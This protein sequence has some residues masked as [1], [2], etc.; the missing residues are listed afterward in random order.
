MLLTIF[1]KI[2]RREANPESVKKINSVL[3]KVN[4]RTVSYMGGL[5]FL[6]LLAFGISVDGF[7]VA[8]DFWQVNFANKVFEGRTD[9]IWKNFTS[10]YL[11]IPSLDFYR[12]LLGF[13]FLFD[14]AVYKTWSP[15]YHATN[16]LFYIS[17]VIMLFIL[18]RR[19]TRSWPENNSQSVSYLGAALFAVSPLHCEDVCW[20]SGRAD[21]LC[22]PIYLFSMWCVV[23][24]HQD[25][26]RR[27]YIMALVS[28]VLALMSK[29]IGVGLPLVI[30]AY[31]FLWPVEESYAEL[32]DMPKYGSTRFQKERINRHKAHLEMVLKD[33]RKRKKKKDEKKKEEEEALRLE[34]EG[35][36]E[37]DGEDEDVIT[38]GDRFKFA[39]LRSWPFFVLAVLY[40]CVRY[41]ALGTFI[42]GYTGMIGGSLS[43]HLILRWF[44]LSYLYRILIPV[45]DI[46]ASQ[47]STPVWT[48]GICLICASVVVAIRLFAR[49]DPRK[50]L[51]F[52]FVW[53]VSTTL[54]LVKLWGLG[55]E[56]ETSRLL[57]FFTMAY[58]ALWPVL[59]FHPGR[60]QDAFK[61]PKIA[62]R[63]LGILSAIILS[64]VVVAYAWIAFS[65]SIFWVLGG[66]ELRSVWRQTVS[67][68]ESL[69]PGERI[70][71]LGVP[72]DLHGAHVSFNGST[73][74]TLL[75]P[76]FVKENLSD[77]VITFEPY[78]V[79]PAEV[80]NATRFKIYLGSKK[81]KGTYVWK[82]ESGKLEAVEFK[83]NFI[84]TPSLQLPLEKDGETASWKLVGK[85][86]GTYKEVDGK[87][88]L[89][90]EDIKD[91]DALKLTGLDLSPFS[92]DFLE[93]DLRV[94]Q[95]KGDL[96]ALLPTAVSWNHQS[97]DQ[98]R[99]DWVVIALKPDKL[100]KFQTVRL[101]LSHYWRWFTSSAINSFV[102]RLPEGVSV[103]FKD[104][105]LVKG[106]DKIPLTYLANHRLLNNGE[107]LVERRDRPIEV[108]FDATMIPGASSIEAQ[109]TKPNYF[110]DSYMMSRR[111]SAVG[112]SINFDSARGLLVLKPELFPEAAYYQ[113]RVRARNSA[114][115]LIGVWS[116]PLTFIV[117]G[118]KLSTYVE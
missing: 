60:K 59:M 33:R 71:V 15:G 85:A 92:F 38:V 48:V 97:V 17:S 58:S 86:K 6:S 73:F 36:A 21:I 42:G 87:R 64:T 61:L 3:G 18:L 51:L 23:K 20:I 95:K 94:R 10:N 99:E 47:S 34:E 77:R 83:G 68:A 78:I 118:D 70:M 37:V 53:M 41:L 106:K 113:I 40:L 31:Y 93:L 101:R 29:E 25:G 16:L 8:D 110:F 89:S 114:G 9:L 66:N 75:R 63:S 107:F 72:K 116:D 104:I 7:F 112:Q 111:E 74:H 79:G 115:E 103:D 22:A 45:P 50:W 62:D 12:P 96:R 27:F 81:V 39:L 105:R 69:G 88:M 56:L 44:D 52:L 67:I 55:K 11:Q 98:N 46:V 35:D 14:Y 49:S 109:L 108:V 28:Y 57:F 90:V 82:R 2:F 26:G 30:A 24:N 13:T 19:M 117:R 80:F 65:T 1:Q 32:V 84:G 5:V 4:L 76:P 54:P 100:E 91:G 102:V 43:Q